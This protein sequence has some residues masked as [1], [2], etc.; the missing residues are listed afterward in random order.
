MTQKFNEME[1]CSKDYTEHQG[2]G[3]EDVFNE[4][5]MVSDIADFVKVLLKNGQQVRMWYDGMTVCIEYNY[6]DQSM[7]G[8]SLEWL[9]PDEY[10]ETYAKEEDTEE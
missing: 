9:G 10:V 4:V 5:E 6:L 2:Y 7:G 1:I 8:V 3:R